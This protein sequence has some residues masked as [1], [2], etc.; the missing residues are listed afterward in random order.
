MEKLMIMMVIIEWILF[1]YYLAYNG[2]SYLQMD[3]D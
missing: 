2:K 3:N 1:I